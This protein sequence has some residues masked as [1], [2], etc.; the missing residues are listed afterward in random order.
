MPCI[1]VVHGRLRR[2]GP[3]A[4]RYNQDGGGWVPR[5]MV[6][7]TGRYNTS[8]LITRNRARP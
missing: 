1:A 6:A 2:R 4:L 8:A 3:A 5:H 7:V